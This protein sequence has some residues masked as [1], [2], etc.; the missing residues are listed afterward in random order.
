MYGS[1][2]ADL[3]AKLDREGLVRLLHETE[4][5]FRFRE[6]LAVTE[7]PIANL[8]GK[9]VLE[10][11]C[12]AGSHSALFASHGAQV[13]ALD[14]SFERAKATGEKF[15]LLGKDAHGSTSLEGDA[16]RLPFDD[17]CFDIVYSNGVLHHSP[18]TESAIVEL[19]RV[20]KPDGLAVVMLYCK[21]SINYWLTLWFGYGIVR[22][23]L[24]KSGVD[25]LGARTEWA[26][27]KDQDIEN[28]ITRCYNRAGIK[29]LFARF[30]DVRIRKSEF[31]ISHLPKVGKWWHRRLDRVGRMHP[32]GLLPYGAP[33]P[34]STR[35]ESW[36]GRYLGWAW[37][38]VAVKPRQ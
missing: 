11:G 30:D 34:I 15:R 31:S 10:I 36:L 32:G 16:E 35:F 7:M 22:G 28:P 33:W 18:D 14:L 24:W 9:R 21:T 37:N 27:A 17:N 8:S 19:H 5:M 13:V 38:I 6:H 12:G 2:Y 26:G 25:R 29:R 23:G 1:A 4:S 20:L 3:D